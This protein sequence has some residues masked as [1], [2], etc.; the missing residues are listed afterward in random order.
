MSKVT[1]LL[2][3]K[4]KAFE[5]EI[6]DI[7]SSNSELYKS[8][9]ISKSE[10]AIPIIRDGDTD[11]LIIDLDKKSANESIDLIKSLENEKMW[12]PTIVARTNGSIR[13]GIFDEFGIVQFIEGINQKEK[14]KET[15]EHIVKGKQKSDF[16]SGLNLSTILQIIELE[17]KTCVVT[18]KNET[19]EGII[20]FS[21]GKLEDA[22][23]GDLSG[24]PAL[25]E[26]FAMKDKMISIKYI[27]HMR[28]KLGE[29][30]SKLLMEFAFKEDEIYKSQKGGFQMNVKK[31]NEAIEAQKE[32]LGPAL[33]STDII[34]AEDG[35]SIAGYNSNPKG[36]ALF[37]QLTQMIVKT[38]KDSGM[39][40]LGRYYIL[41][42]VDDKMAIILYL[43]DFIWGMLIDKKKTQLGLL[44]N[45][46]I[47]SMV[48]AFEAAIAS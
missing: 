38:V 46:V 23:F 47:P 41:D 27:Q 7:F 2:L 17:N 35:Q 3:T 10:E 1:L 18:V 20:F 37:N 24:I 11:V 40:E 12:I 9:V 14:I 26:I 25:E 39:P 29:S 30:I 33:L 31:L 16:I 4:D 43:G 45:I 36:A 21:E 19:Q 8:I 32:A 28:K 48:D 22:K 42:L 15:I 6:K 44:L 5:K 13:Q 34:M